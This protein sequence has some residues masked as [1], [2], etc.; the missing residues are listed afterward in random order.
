MNEQGVCPGSREDFKVYVMS[1]A[2]KDPHFFVLLCSCRSS[3][4]NFLHDLCP[5][6]E[7]ATG[8]CSRSLNLF[9]LGQT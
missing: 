5:F 9:L 8:T 6:W 1:S 4:F 7:K 2:L 3:F